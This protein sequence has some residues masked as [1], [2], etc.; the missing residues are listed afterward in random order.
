MPLGRVRQLTNNKINR[1]IKKP[2]LRPELI[3][4]LVLRKRTEWKSQK[5]SEKLNQVTCFSPEKSRVKCTFILIAINYF[6]SHENDKLSNEIIEW[7]HLILHTLPL[8]SIV[9]QNV[10]RLQKERI[11]KKINSAYFERL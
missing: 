1:K 8:R 6:Q 4:F 10:I 3:V 11:K 5:A 2:Y 7:I 9:I